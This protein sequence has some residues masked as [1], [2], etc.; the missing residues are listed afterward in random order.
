MHG[1]EFALIRR[2][3]WM[4]KSDTVQIIQFMM[5]FAMRR[6][7]ENFIQPF[8]W[9]ARFDKAN[10]R[11]RPNEKTLS[12]INESPYDSVTWPIGWQ[13]VVYEGGGI[14]KASLKQPQ[15]VRLCP[16]VIDP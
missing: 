8:F 14:D 11:G 6:R 13:I 4:Y 7:T 1:I 3:E 10:A 2:V 16:I 9:I 12:T 15:D 5:R